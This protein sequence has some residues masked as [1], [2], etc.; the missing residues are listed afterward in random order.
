MVAKMERESRLRELY[1]AFN[2]RDAGGILLFD[3]HVLHVYAYRG[4]F[5]ER[6]TIEAADELIGTRLP[7]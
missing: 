1:A 2:A 7:A 5:V 6:M 3:Q 4:D